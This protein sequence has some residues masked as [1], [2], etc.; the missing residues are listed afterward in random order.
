MLLIRGRLILAAAAVAAAGFAGTAIGAG[1][2]SRPA[3]PAAVDS[4]NVCVL[5]TGSRSWCGDTGPADR[6]KL[7]APSDVAV[8][9]D[10]SLLIADTLNNVV[11]RVR[12]NGTIVSIAG[13]GEQGPAVRRDGAAQIGFDA[14]R[15]VA[16]AGN[17]AV[18]VADTGNNAIRSISA[19]GTV[20][21]LVSAS[22]PTQVHL[23]SPTDVTPAPNGGY[24]ISDTGNNRVLSVA[25]TG[26]VEVIAGSGR[27]GYSGDGGPASRAQLKRPTEVFAGPDGTVLIADTGNG[28]VRRVALSGV[29]DTVTRGLDRPEGVVGL[30]GGAAIVA[31]AGALYRVEPDGSRSTIAG[32]PRA[33]FNGDSGQALELRFDDL[34]QIASTTDGRLVF[35]ERGS[36]RIRVVETTGAVSTIA[37]SGAP[38]PAPKVGIPAGAF[39]PE[40]GGRPA[41]SQPPRAASD[42]LAAADSTSQCE[43]YDA[44]FAS[45][46]LIP[47]SEDTLPAKRRRSKRGRRQIVLR[48]ASSRPATVV[49]EITRNRKPGGRAVRHRIK[50]G[51]QGNR[52]RINGRF[53]RRTYIARLYG[54]SVKDNVKRCDVKRVRVR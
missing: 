30:P 3:P 47:M 29:I 39:P 33:G 36:D 11:R 24:L 25:P 28:A 46:T 10:G 53:A 45:F 17:G 42:A 43:R 54:R 13:T 41:G 34:A 52:I 8:A 49:I 32:G 5:E 48:F 12:A 22:G 40:L 19:N 44:R 26:A 23:D 14:P 6:A 9:E 1:G 27:A 37:G 16:A 2:Q 7:A 51:R 4:P 21:T 35:A 15:G 31:S 50:V 18:L 20:R 38:R